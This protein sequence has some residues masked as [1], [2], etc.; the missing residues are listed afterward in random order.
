MYH[1]ACSRLWYDRTL[2]QRTIVLRFVQ[3][4]S[5]PL[6]DI[7]LKKISK[8][9]L[10]V[11]NYPVDHLLDISNII[12]EKISVEL[13]EVNLIDILHSAVKAVLAKAESKRIEINL[14]L[15]DIT[16]LPL[17]LDNDKMRQVFCNLLDNAIKFTPEEGEINVT[18]IHNSTEILIHIQDNGIGISPEFL[19]YIFQYLTRADQ[20]NKYSGLGLG[21]A[22]VDHLLKLQGGQITASSPGLNQGATFTVSLPYSFQL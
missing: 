5:G 14:I 10:L 20:S 17:L 18:L 13:K 8:N 3:D 19:P 7:L 21:L 6:S 1:A 9:R 15:P 2:A 11:K 12:L 16:A 22:I 4:H